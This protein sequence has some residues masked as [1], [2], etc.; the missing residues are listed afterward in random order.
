VLV[1]AAAVIVWTQLAHHAAGAAHVH[2]TAHAGAGVPAV[3][4]AAPTVPADAGPSA[5]VAAAA[6]A[7]PAAAAHRHRAQ[8]VRRSRHARAHD[9]R[10]HVAVVE[11]TSSPGSSWSPA[12]VASSRPAVLRHWTPRPVHRAGSTSAPASV[13]HSPA[14]V[15]V[16][17][18]PSHPSAAPSA[19][20]IQLVPVS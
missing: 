11:R 9:A 13:A 8:H 4:P 17:G 19:G 3:E 14:P 6:K 5:D 15:H 12:A 16:S 20:P 1:V 7:P 10:E 2:V 18:H